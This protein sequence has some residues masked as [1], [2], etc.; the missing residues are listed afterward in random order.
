MLYQQRNRLSRAIAGI[1]AEV[2][3]LDLGAGAHHAVLD[4]FLAA[5]RGVLVV[6]PEAPSIEN[7]YR[8]L[9]AA[10]LRAIQ[11]A[12]IESDLLAT[13]REL[14]QDVDAR[15]LTPAELI[16]RVSA[17]DPEAGHIVRHA[18]ASF[19]PLLVINQASIPTDLTLA[20]SLAR[21]SALLF[22]VELEPLGHVHRCELLARAVRMRLPVVFENL[23]RELVTDVGAVATKLL[24]ATG[25]EPTR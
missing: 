1:D 19:R 24:A 11:H 17:T 18:G 14:D 12:G 25:L 9:K 20:T 13:I 2:V 4:F 22:G 7:V 3:I 23:G 8:F 15:P 6:V 16:S 10:F 21:A 5:P